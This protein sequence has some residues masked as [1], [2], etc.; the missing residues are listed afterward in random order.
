MSKFNL[1]MLTFDVEDWFQAPNLKDMIRKDSWGSKELRVKE[2][3]KKLLSILDKYETKATFFILGWVAERIPDLVREI[4]GR[5]HEIACHGYAH[6]L[7]Y[8]LSVDGFRE[9]IRRSRNI[10]AD[11]TGE[12]ILG[13]R[14][15]C[16]SITEWALDVLNEE[17]FK[18]DSSFFPS[19]AHDR[20]GKL[21]TANKTNSVQEVRSGFFEVLIPTLDFIGIRIPWGGG[22][23]FR[24]IPYAF[25]KRGV[26]IISGNEGVFVFYLHPWEIDPLQPHVHGIKLQYKIRHYSGLRKTEGK[27]KQLLKD[28]RFDTIKSG[29]GKLGFL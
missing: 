13:Y 1:C 20:Y 16:F 28:F 29:L 3:T 27:L 6:E 15:P 21:I 25:Y 22:A 23:Y 18:Y 10:L 11:I 4:H 12:K 2:N 17:K 8:N 19:M 26:R 7:I 9:D 14:A 5:G 24:L